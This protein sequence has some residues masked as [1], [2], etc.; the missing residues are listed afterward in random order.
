MHHPNRSVRKADVEIVCI[1]G[2]ISDVPFW[3]VLE[4]ET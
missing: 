2:A 3:I 1:D 4:I